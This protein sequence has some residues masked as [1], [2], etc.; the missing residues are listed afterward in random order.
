M[1]DSKVYSLKEL[2]ADKFEVDF[3]QREYVWQRKQ[4]E[5]L[6]IDLSTEFLKN[7]NENDSIKE[8]AGYDPYFMGEIVISLN[9]NDK[10]NSIIDGQQRITTLTL[11][12]IYLIRNYGD[13]NVDKFPTGQISDLIYSDYYGEKLF[14]LNIAERAECMKNLFENGNHEIKESDSISVINLVDR[15]NDI[16]ECWHNEI[17][18]SN[19]TKF[20]YWIIE[21]IMF[22]KVWTNN[23]EFAY[24]IFETMND[25]GLSLTQV[26]M[27][28]SYLLANIDKDERNNQLA[29][30][31]SIVKRLLE[32]KLTSKS[33]AEF[34]FFKIY[35]RGHFAQEITP[36][37][38]YESDFT[39]IGKEFHR[40]LRE[41]SGKLD[42]KTSSDFVEFMD[43][44][45]YF[46]KKYR[47][48]NDIMNNRNV[49]D[50]FYLI[51]NSDYG[52]TLQPA[53][54]LSGIK[55]KDSDEVVEQK[56]KLISKY[57]TKVLSWRVWNHWMI[58]QSSLENQIYE[59]AK[60]IR[61]KDIE[62]IKEVLNGE[63]IKIPELLNAP[64]LNQQ[65]RSK[66]RVLLGLITEIVARNSNESKYMLNEKDIEVEH[67]WSNHYDQ[68]L[69]EFELEVDF[70][71]AR[72]NI[73]DLLLLPK[74]FNASY[75]DSHYDIKVLQYFS[76]NILAQT[77]NNKKYENNPGFMNYKNESKLN[78]K[79]YDKFTKSSINERA[80]LYKDILKWNFKNK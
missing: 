24:V 77:L 54:I 67:I 39:K 73:G 21:K 75:G 36:S 65:N 37:K 1:V 70:A 58:S 11:L 7:H 6:I 31:D 53:L 78:F 64:T 38:T 72:N 17:N 47:M 62:E 68:H 8:V 57:L 12:L 79:H 23:D 52:F 46:S 69:D 66:L 49:K 42:L 22:S 27:L 34:E 50:Y 2:F 28:K 3:Y 30:F 20:A 25:R 44:L 15:F 41:N 56:I 61:D 63:P 9:S 59:L 5:D 29:K 32:I 51:V 10:L 33:K 4:L 43:K 40:W 13:G 26:E 18:E 74:S 71:N 60:I 35:F 16:N 19:I 55:Y 45:D 14:N 48:L 80:E 76:Q